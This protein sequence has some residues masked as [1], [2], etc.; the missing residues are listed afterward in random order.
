[1]LPIH[2]GRGVSIGSERVPNG[3]ALPASVLVA[4][5]VAFSAFGCGGTEVT[6]EAPPPPEVTVATPEQRDVTNYLEFTGQTRAFEAVEVVARIPGV[7]QEMHFDPSTTVDEGDLLFVIEPEPYIASRDAADADVKTWEA[8]VVRATADLERLEQAIQTNAV[9][10]QEVDRARADLQQ[11][12][13]NLLGAKAHLNEA[14]INLDYTQVRSPI[15]GLVSR[16]LVDVGNLVGSTGSTVLTTVV[17]I[18]PIYAYFDMSERYLLE[19]LAV[20]D[21]TVAEAPREDAQAYLG[22]ANEEGW[23]HEGQL[24]YIDNTV[25][26]DTG[27]IQIRAIFPN[28]RG[29]L[30]PGL[31]ARIRFPVSIEEDALLVSEQAI[32]TDLGGKYLLIVGDGNVVELRHVDLGAQED[33]MRVIRSGLAAGERYIINGLQRARPGLPVTPTQGGS[34]GAGG[35]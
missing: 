20:R 24:D 14:E 4:A 10:A 23:P 13:A 33:D 6:T 22:L 3:R 17:R 30:F 32:G 21:A 34:A 8:E 16:N 29:Q 25:N 2:I 1:M 19:A 18:N 31:F 5:V 11:A 26:T 9:S 15:S 28:R 27:T 12:E 35:R 7:L